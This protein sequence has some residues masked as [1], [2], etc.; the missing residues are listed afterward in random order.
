MGSPIHGL[1]NTD[2][3]QEWL[4]FTFVTQD[5]SLLVINIFFSNYSCKVLFC[6]LEIIAELKKK[7]LTR[8]RFSLWALAESV[9]PEGMLTVFTPDVELGRHSEQELMISRVGQ[10]VHSQPRERTGYCVARKAS[11]H[12]SELFCYLYTY[13]SIENKYTGLCPRSWAQR[14]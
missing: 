3:N 10:A 14:P 5:T 12:N 4:S 2:V 13:E 9:P 8:N 7:I 6:F 1:Q 11:Y